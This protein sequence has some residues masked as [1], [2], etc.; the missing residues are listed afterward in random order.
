MVI[1]GEHFFRFNHPLEVEHGA[2]VSSMTEKGGFQFAKEEYVKMQTAR[3]AMM[4]PYTL[5]TCR[6]NKQGVNQIYFLCMYERNWCVH[7]V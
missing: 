1:G 2:K 3:S 6:H 4:L 7:I 5:Y